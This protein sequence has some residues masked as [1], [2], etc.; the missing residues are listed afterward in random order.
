LHY[1]AFKASDV[2]A[3]TSAGHLLANGH[4]VKAFLLFMLK[5][6]FQLFLPTFPH[7]WKRTTI[8]KGLNHFLNEFSSIRNGFPICNKGLSSFLLVFTTWV[9]I[10]VWRP[11][12]LTFSG[13][14]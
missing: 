14:F 4:F 11:L 1:F 6:I 5:V 9:F 2:Q 13:K 3:I 12:L 7:C 8:N 10:G